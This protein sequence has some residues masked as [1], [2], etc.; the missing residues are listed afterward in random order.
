MR[1][2]AQEEKRAMSPSSSSSS[3]CSSSSPSNPTVES[4]PFTETGEKNFYDTEGLD[5]KASAE[6]PVEEEQGG[7]K[8]YSMDEIWK[9]IE[10]TLIPGDDG[11]TE[12]GSSFPCP[13][14]DF[15]TWDQYH[16][17][18][19]WTMAEESKMFLPTSDFFPCSDFGTAYLTG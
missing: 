17:E 9:D 10:N 15:P 4:L 1:K 19:P 12:E 2:K 5:I 14:L 11:Y 6:K 13:T 7:E 3:N 8:G 16:S 18:S